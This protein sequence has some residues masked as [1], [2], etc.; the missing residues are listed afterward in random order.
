MNF[1]SL[2]LSAFIALSAFGGVAEAATTPWTECG[3]KHS[4]QQTRIMACRGT[5]YTGW[6]RLEWADG[7]SDTFTK[8]SNGVMRDSLGGL[9]DAG[10]SYGNNG[11]YMFHLVSRNSGTVIVVSE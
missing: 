11:T 5:F 10:E 2:A 1:K 3:F 9:W 7:K 4:G 8:V 6:L